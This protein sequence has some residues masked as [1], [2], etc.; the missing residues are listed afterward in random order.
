M[1]ELGL[2]FTGLTP[3]GLTVTPVKGGETGKT[4]LEGVLAVSK[5][6]LEMDKTGSSQG[7]EIPNT[8]EEEL[9]RL[10]QQLG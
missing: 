8:T 10:M 7:S 6:V 9:S 2:G 5:P 4:G 1:R 3:T